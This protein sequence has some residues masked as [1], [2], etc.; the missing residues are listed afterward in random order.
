MMSDQTLQIGDKIIKLGIEYCF[1]GDEE[2]DCPVCGTALY[3]QEPYS[4]SYQLPTR[5]SCP[6]V[7]Y[8]WERT[9]NGGHFFFVRPDFAKPFILALIKS[10]Y[11]REF[12]QNPHRNNPPTDRRPMHHPR[13]LKNNEIALFASGIFSSGDPMFDESKASAEHREL[14]DQWHFLGA[15]YSDDPISAASKRQLLLVGF[16][17]YLERL[18]YE[19]IGAKVGNISHAIPSIEHPECLPDNVVVYYNYEG[20]STDEKHDGRTRTIAIS[21]TEYNNPGVRGL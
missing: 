15:L 9:R 20:V 5:A 17:R 18:R 7:L 19:E 12:L 16:T 13:P 2:L 6:H 3:R 4:G 11:Y 8:Y 21:P 10:D 1:F 14:M